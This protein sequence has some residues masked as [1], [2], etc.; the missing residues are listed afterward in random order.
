[1]RS[2]FSGE[3]QWPFGPL[4]YP[5]AFV[6]GMSQKCFFFL[7]LG[8]CTDVFSNDL[9]KQL[10]MFAVLF[11]IRKVIKAKYLNISLI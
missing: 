6:L 10:Q 4:V 5:V 9:K 7:Y 3:R 2:L 8:I 1:M 11:A